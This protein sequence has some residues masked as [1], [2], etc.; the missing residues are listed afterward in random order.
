MSFEEVIV[1]LFRPVYALAGVPAAIADCIR[2]VLE[3]GRA[4]GDCFLRKK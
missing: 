3:S 2:A 1:A 4:R